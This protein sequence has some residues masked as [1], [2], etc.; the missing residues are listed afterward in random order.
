M[1]VHWQ[2]KSV[3]QEFSQSVQD[4]KNDPIAFAVHVQLC[5]WHNKRP[6]QLETKSLAHDV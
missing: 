5:S 6:K 3:P 2:P 4:D 1:P